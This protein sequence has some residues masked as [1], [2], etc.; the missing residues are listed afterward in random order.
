MTAITLHRRD[1]A[2]NPQRYYVLY[3]KQY[4]FGAWCFVREWGR[5]GQRGG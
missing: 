3:M 5:L 2:K 1:P 4:P